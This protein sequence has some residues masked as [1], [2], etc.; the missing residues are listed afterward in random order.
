METEEVRREQSWYIRDLMAYM[1]GIP[2][3][4]L[5][6]LVESYQEDGGAPDPGGLFRYLS[7]RGKKYQILW[8]AV[9]FSDAISVLF[10]AVMGPN[11]ALLWQGSSVVPF[12]LDSGSLRIWNR[13]LEMVSGVAIPTNPQV[14]ETD[15]WSAEQIHRGLRKLWDRWVPRFL[16]EM[17]LWLAGQKETDS[18][19][20]EDPEL[21]VRLSLDASREMRE[22]TGKGYPLGAV[23]M[24]LVSL[25]DLRD[26]GLEVNSLQAALDSFVAQSLPA[27]EEGGKES[28]EPSAGPGISGRIVDVRPQ[29]DPLEGV[30]LSELRPG[31]LLMLDGLGGQGVE[32][33]I[34]MIR[35][36]KGGQYEVHG[37]FGDEGETFFRFV[38]PGEIKLR[39][40]PE[41][42]RPSRGIPAPVW[43]AL[44]F[45]GVVCLLLLIWL[46]G[47]S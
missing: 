43:G 37:H 47:G 2:G 34:Y 29:V 23:R 4:D 26:M 16:G 10:A 40:P 7:A 24:A 14:S 21:T 38:C 28:A 8:A 27:T 44:G 25:P 11:K 46:L 20:L 39:M 13:V 22:V 3:E 17:D 1:L 30:A 9:P 33:K 6:R 15:L 32:G 36:L 5:E 42:P 41:A 18:L 31:D 45:L 12:G 19:V 35:L